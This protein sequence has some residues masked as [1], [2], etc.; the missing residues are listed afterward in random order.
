[1]VMTLLSHF[2]TFIILSPHK[3]ADV[4][5]NLMLMTL[6]TE[7]G[8]RHTTIF[9]FFRFIGCVVLELTHIHYLPSW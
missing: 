4:A 9:N 8:L 1:M 6:P 3:F 2:M 5:G 7:T